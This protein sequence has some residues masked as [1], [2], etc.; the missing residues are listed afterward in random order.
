MPQ[1]LLE[2]AEYV[3][4]VVTGQCRDGILASLCRANNNLL[5]HLHT[6]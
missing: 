5:M 2:R 3:L 6:E 4:S 1:L